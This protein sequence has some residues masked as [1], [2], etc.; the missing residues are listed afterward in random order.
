MGSCHTGQSSSRESDHPPR[1]ESHPIERK[2]VSQCADTDAGLGSRE[3]K[4]KYIQVP[5]SRSS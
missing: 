4:Q 1:R 2:E 5:D 3:K